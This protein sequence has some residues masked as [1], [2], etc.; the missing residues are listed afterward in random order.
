MPTEVNLSIFTN[1]FTT[2]IKFREQGAGNFAF[3]FAFASAEGCTTALHAD[4]KLNTTDYENL[5]GMEVINH[6]SFVAT[7]GELQIKGVVDAKSINKI[8]KDQN[9]ELTPDEINTFVKADL[10]R[11]NGKIADVKYE[12]E[13]GKGVI[14]FIYS[15]GSREKAEQYVSDFEKR[16][17][18]IFKRFDK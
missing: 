4:V 18:E 5:T 12:K 8:T 7:Q 10:Y 16:V 2:T 13:N 1:P 3:D 17:T 6:I 14:Y 15:D 9:H 11:G